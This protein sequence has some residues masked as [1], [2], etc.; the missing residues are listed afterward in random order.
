MSVVE[1]VTVFDLSECQ[2][3]PQCQAIPAIYMFQDPVLTKHAHIVA[4]FSPTAT[5]Q[6]SIS[7]RIED[8]L[9]VQVWLDDLVCLNTFV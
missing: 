4:I 2:T 3:L 8:L 9:D 6:Q 1:I 5:N 7:S